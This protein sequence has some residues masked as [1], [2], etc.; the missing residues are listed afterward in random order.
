MNRDTI[1]KEFVD[2]I[3]D[4]QKLALNIAGEQ[5]SDDLMQLCSL[6]LL[7]F[8]EARLISYY[9]P[10]QGLKPFFIRMLINQ[11]K[12]T[13]SKFHKLYRKQELEIQKKADDIILNATVSIDK[14]M[15]R[16]ILTR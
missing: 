7:E 6:E 13:T 11:Y 9:N 12:S 5:D 14:I 15:S 8:P 4:F 10:T 16:D 2:N 3:K 1:I